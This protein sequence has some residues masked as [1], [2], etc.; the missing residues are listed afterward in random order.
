[1]KY[2]IIL[3]LNL[4]IFFIVSYTPDGLPDAE[5]WDFINSGNIMQNVD[6]KN[7]VIGIINDIPAT[8]NAIIDIKM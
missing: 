1:M 6:T 3:I 7:D 2:I 8:K 4:R 5:F